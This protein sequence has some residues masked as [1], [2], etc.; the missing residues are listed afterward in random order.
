MYIHLE[1]EDEQ[2]NAVEFIQKHHHEGFLTE[3]EGIIEHIQDELRNATT[4]VYFDCMTLNNS[5]DNEKKMLQIISK[6]KAIESK[7]IDL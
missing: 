5:V 6:L 1:L 3:M 2:F 4:N 7:I